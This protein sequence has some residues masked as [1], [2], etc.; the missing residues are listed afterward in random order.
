M[1]VNAAL[2]QHVDQPTAGTQL[3]LEPL[4]VPR[5]SQL[6]QAQHEHHAV[7]GVLQQTPQVQ[8]AN[9]SI[10]ADANEHQA[11]MENSPDHTTTLFGLAARQGDAVTRPEHVHAVQGTD[12][13]E[14]QLLDGTTGE[15]RNAAGRRETQ[16]LDALGMKH[17]EWG[18]DAEHCS[19]IQTSSH[20]LKKNTEEQSFMRMFIC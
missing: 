6:V 13:G 19:E 14:G 20:A 9:I 15:E 3:S 1:T 2:Q 4:Y 12:D 11:V 8:L 18:R 16:E 10:A 7:P 17:A 5:V